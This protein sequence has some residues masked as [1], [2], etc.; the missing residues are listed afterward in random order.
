AGGGLVETGENIQRRG[1]AR[2]VRPDQ[3]VNAAAPDLDIDV[4]DCLQAAEMLGKALDGKNDVAARDG[5]HEL[6][7]GSRDIDFGFGVPA[8][9]CDLDE[10]PDAVRHVAD[11][12]D[13]REAVDRKIK[14]G[15]AL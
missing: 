9:G 3:G 7:R 14:A 4:I 13:D 15:N 10:T 12:Q 11:D 1:L 8:L 2:A 6:Q 5:G